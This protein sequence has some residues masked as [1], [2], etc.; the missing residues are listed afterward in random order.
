M[1]CVPP[2]PGYLQALRGITAQAKTL[3]IM[4]EVMTGFRLAYGGAQAIFSIQPDLTTLGKII[5]GGLPVGAYGGRAGI[6]N[7][8]A[9]LRP[10]YQ[11]GTPSGNT[12]ANA[13]GPGT[14]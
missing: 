9:P 14:P 4:D 2:A 7:L 11:A 5:G 8:V 6:I 12:P 3:L 10:M 13:A 1:G